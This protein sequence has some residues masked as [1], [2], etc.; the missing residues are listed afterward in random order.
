MIKTVKEI[1]ARNFLYHYYGEIHLYCLVYD[2]RG[3]IVKNILRDFQISGK[4]SVNWDGKNNN[5]I[6][7]SFEID[8]YEIQ[9]KYSHQK[10]KMLLLK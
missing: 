4:Y 9:T 1:I 6:A 2:S 3:K 7:I 10:R 5:G 8:F